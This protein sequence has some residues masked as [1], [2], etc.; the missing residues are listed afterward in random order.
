[1]TVL[2]DANVLNGLSMPFEVADQ[3][4]VTAYGLEPTDTVTFFMVQ[5]NKTTPVPCQCP[6][7]MVVMPAVVDEMQLLC[8]NVAITLTR[9]KPF[10]II[11]SPQGVKLRAKL[12]TTG[13]VPPSTQLVEYKVTTTKN[14]TERMRGCACAP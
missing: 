12:N 13:N 4:T 8:C 2:I 11:D 5:L 7:G 10:V 6:P 1:M 3:V 14:V 9:Q